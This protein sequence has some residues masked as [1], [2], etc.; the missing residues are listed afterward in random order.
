MRPLRREM[1]M[2]FQDPY[3]SLN[4]RQTVGQII[5]TPFAIHKTEGSTKRK[6]QELMDRVG[7]N[8]EHYNRYPHEFSGGQRQRIGVARALALS[9]KLIVCDE[10]VSALDVSIQAQIL[11]LLPGLQ[12]DFDLTYLFISHDL[13]VVRHVSD[14]IAVM[15]LGR[16]VEIG[17]ADQVYANPKHPYTAALLSAVP[18]GGGDGD[19]PRTHRARPATCRRRSIRRPAAPFTPGARRPALVT[20]RTRTRSRRSVAGHPDLRRSSLASSR[21]WY[22]LSER[23]SPRRLPGTGRMPANGWSI[24]AAAR[25]TLIEHV[26]ADQPTRVEGA[27]GRRRVADTLDRRPSRRRRAGVGPQAGFGV[28]ESSNLRLTSASGKRWLAKPVERG[29]CRAREWASLRLDGEL[30]ELERLLLRGTSAVARAAAVR[31]GRRAGDGGDA[32]RRRTSGP[33]SVEHSLAASRRRKRDRDRSGRRRRVAVGATAGV[34]A[35]DRRRAL[36]GG[37]T[38]VGLHPTRSSSRS[39]HEAPRAARPTRRTRPGENV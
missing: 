10:P 11:N 1:Q 18:K 20:G 13:G 30:S 38:A 26:E 32:G 14:R 4:P 22:P 7:L 29:C 25:P 33:S 36:A 35:S 15:Y 21:C 6:V 27:S 3:S 16:I 5:G 28:S 12:Q 8:P 2:V 24:S 39:G 19:A 23:R 17:A 34:L 37:P 31:G 9:P